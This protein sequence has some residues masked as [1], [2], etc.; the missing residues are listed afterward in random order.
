VPSPADVF[1]TPGLPPG[2]G[3][4]VGIVGRTI[5]GRIFSGLGTG[6]NQGPPILSGAQ[7]IANRR[8]FDPRFMQGAVDVGA[9]PGVDISHDVQDGRVTT[10]VGD[11]RQLPPRVPSSADTI[12][13]PRKRWLSRAAK[14][15]KLAR[16]GELGLIL[17]VLEESVSKT[18]S[19]DTISDAE[20]KRR[21]GKT[22]KLE[23]IKVTASRI[24]YPRPLTRIQV[25]AK[26]LPRIETLTPVKVTAKRIRISAPR[27]TKTMPRPVLGGVG[28]LSSMLLPYLLTGTQS[29]RDPLTVNIRDGVQ[30]PPLTEP[31]PAGSTAGFSAGFI[32]STSCDCPP[33]KPK[34]KGKKR[35]VCYQ[36][37]YTERADGLTKRKKRKI[38]C[39]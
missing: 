16:G 19:D 22:G 23:R 1:G 18:A 26:R 3:T 14:L 5:I 9:T 8:R 21:F 32:G 13:G 15:K 37:T 6:W 7:V 17:T 30:S 35:T 29:R 38:P 39:K 12:K 2:V 4:V 31:L 10:R 24:S 25:T 34:R 36:G 27:P 28:S 20:Y 33:K 11:R